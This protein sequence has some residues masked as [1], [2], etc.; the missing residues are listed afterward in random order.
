MHLHK[1]RKV[2]KEKYKIKMG[3]KHAIVAILLSIAMGGC[4]IQQI[5]PEEKKEDVTAV[6]NEKEA[7]T[8]IEEK[9]Q[10]KVEPIYTKA[11]YISIETKRLNVRTDADVDSSQIGG[12]YQYDKFQI[13]DTKRD[14]EKRLWYKIEVEPGTQGYV[15][16]WF[17][18]ETEITI[19]VEGEKATIVE[20]DV[21]PQPKYLDNPFDPEEAK[22]GDEIVGLQITE[23]NETEGF[24]SIIFR[25]KAELTGYYYHETLDN[26][27]VVRFVPDEA[28]SIL[29][30]RIDEEVKNVTFLISNYEEVKDS[31]GSMGS[32]GKVTLVLDRYVLY[33]KN[34][35]YNRANIVEVK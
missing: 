29:L 12:V 17:C 31:F 21:K 35:N 30:P 26:V 28:S 1:N 11:S 16:G 33:K 4:S 9:T 34:E 32:T 5:V 19:L 3:K 18:V 10:V 13:I 25:N 8:K 15:A 6:E 23:L 27:P 24:Q 7:E 20:I 2:Q 22:I 14:S